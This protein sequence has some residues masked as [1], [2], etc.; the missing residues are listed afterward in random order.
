MCVLRFAKGHAMRLL[1]AT[2][3]IG[4]ALSSTTPATAAAITIS[5]GWMRALPGN[6]PAGGYFRLHNAGDKPMSLTGASSPAC[7]MLML[8]RSETS[9]GMA[10]M[11]DV[12]KVSIAV[13]ATVSF[14]PG[15]YHLMCMDPTPAVRPGGSIAVTL[16]FDDG[17]KIKS[18][19]VVRGAAGH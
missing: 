18:N 10:R 17:T 16:T 19:F 1:I 9:G 6:L 14:S 15:G 13:G 7:G 3:A 4:L 5:G 12:A 2:L 8:H 11:D